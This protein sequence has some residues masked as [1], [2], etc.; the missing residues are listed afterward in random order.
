M[1]STDFVKDF[2]HFSRKDRIALLLLLVAVLAIFSL[3]AFINEK[4]L[5]PL[6]IA[7]A[8]SNGET[9]QGEKPAAHRDLN[10]EPFSVKPGISVSTAFDPNSIG[11]NGWEKMGLRDRTIRMIMNYRSKG[12]QFRSADDLRK[13]YGLREDE[14]SRLK[15]FIRISGPNRNSPETSPEEKKTFSRAEPVPVTM[16]RNQKDRSIDINLADSA[17]W[18]ALP[19]IGSKLSARILNF[20]EKLGGFYSIDQVA[21]TFGLQD[22]VFQRIK[23]FLRISP[24]ALRKLSINNASEEELRSHPYLRWQLA[25]A[26]L[27]YRQEHGPFKQLEELKGIMAISEEIF[28]KL[29]PYLEL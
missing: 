1:R 18:I 8:R 25:K 7:E 17:A 13:I 16:V 22:S 2:F 28:E 10:A 27:S 5:P 23:P 3:P 20:R 21:Q 24:E 26:I 11:E 4:P 29:R 14:F 12:G 6:I 9:L 19:G 15:P